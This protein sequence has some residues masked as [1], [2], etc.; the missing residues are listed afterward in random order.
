[1]THPPLVLSHP[2]GLCRIALSLPLKGDLTHDFSACLVHIIVN[3][4]CPVHPLP[5]FLPLVIPSS[6]IYLHNKQP[7]QQLK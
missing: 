5:L 2:G 6:G 4:Q 1:M 3:H 7:E